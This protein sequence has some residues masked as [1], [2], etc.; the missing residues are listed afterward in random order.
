MEHSEQSQITDHSSERIESEVME[1]SDH[2]E[3]DLTAILKAKD[4]M[5]KTLQLGNLCFKQKADYLEGKVQDLKNALKESREWASATSRVLSVMPIAVL[6]Q[7]QLQGMLFVFR[8]L[9]DEAESS[10]T[11]DL[12][13][14]DIADAEQSE[15][16]AGD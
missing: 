11:H 12:A 6:S 3:D 8:C 9:L 4:Q 14:S 1:H 13:M 15:S 5:I 10:I 7:Q 16:D 2:P